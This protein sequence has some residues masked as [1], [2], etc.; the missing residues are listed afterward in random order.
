MLRGRLLE[1]CNGMER[2]D[3]EDDARDD[4][5]AWTDSFTMKRLAAEITRDGKVKRLAEL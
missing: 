5:Q 2:E 3:F 1:S 4:T